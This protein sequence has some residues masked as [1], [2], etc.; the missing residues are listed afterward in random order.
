MSVCE[1]LEPISLGELE[2]AAGDVLR[3]R[4]MGSPSKVT[5]K[6]GDGTV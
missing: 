6:G 5:A 4:R 3:S 2:Q 1:V